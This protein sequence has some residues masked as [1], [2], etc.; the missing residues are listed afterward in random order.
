MYDDDD[1]SMI[2]Q[3]QMR[4]DNYISTHVINMLL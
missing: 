4:Y 3:P 2:S 1:T